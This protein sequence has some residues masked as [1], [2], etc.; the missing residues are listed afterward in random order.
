MGLRVRQS[1]SKVISPSSC[2][3]PK[4]KIAQSLDLGFK[5]QALTQYKGSSSYLVRRENKFQNYKL[6]K[7]I[8]CIN[9]II[10]LKKKK[11][12]NPVKV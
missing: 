10:L 6:K 3:P 9:Q 5:F 2:G 8:H 12:N 1:K 4:N 11:P 7:E